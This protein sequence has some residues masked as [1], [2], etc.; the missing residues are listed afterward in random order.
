MNLP[1]ISKVESEDTKDSTLEVF[2]DG[3]VVGS[4]N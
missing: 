4:Y 1:C 3:V 2:I